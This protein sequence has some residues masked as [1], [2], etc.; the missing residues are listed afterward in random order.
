M[1]H[2]LCAIIVIFFW[3]PSFSANKT[4]RTMATG[5]LS[6]QQRPL[7]ARVASSSSSSFMGHCRQLQ[8]K[9]HTSSALNVAGP[10]RLLCMHVLTL[11]IMV[12]RYNA[13]LLFISCIMCV[14]CTHT[15]PKTQSRDHNMRCGPFRGHSSA[16]IAGNDKTGKFSQH[17]CM[18]VYHFFGNT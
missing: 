2:T 5:V 12:R 8:R 18:F 13:L 10:H 7:V 1:G 15:H 16:D 9:T 3:Q 6:H 4:M 17:V 11:A 14:T